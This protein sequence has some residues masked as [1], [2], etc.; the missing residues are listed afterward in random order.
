KKCISALG[1]KVI[2]LEGY[3][4]DDILGTLAKRCEEADA[5]AYLLTGDRD[6]LQLI[7]DHVP[8]LLATN[9]DTVDYTDEVFFE[10]YG[11]HAN[12]YVD[13]KALMGDSSDNIPGIAGIGPKT[14]VNLITEFSTLDG[15]YEGLEASDLKPNMIA[16]LTDGKDSAYLSQTLA[17]INR[18]VPIDTAAEAYKI[19]EIDKE[20]AT[21][22]LSRLGLFKVMAHYS[23]SA[24][25][26]PIAEKTEEKP[27][28]I[29]KKDY[30]LV[31]YPAM[32]EIKSAADG[33]V[34]YIFRDGLIYL[35]AGDKLFVTDDIAGVFSLE[36]EKYTYDCKAQYLYALKNSLP[37]PK[38]SFDLK[39]AAYLLSPTDSDYGFDALTTKFGKAE[40]TLD[41]AA[42]FGDDESAFNDA[43]KLFFLCKT[44]Y[45]ELEKADMLSLLSDI[46]IPL[47][48]T[49]SAMEFEG[50]ELDRE[51]IQAFDRTLSAEIERLRQSIY[52]LAGEEFNVNSPKQLGE[53]LFERLGLPAKKK[54]KTGYSTNA[55]ILERLKERHPIINEILEYRKVSKLKSTYTEGLLLKLGE[56]QRI[57]T[58]FLQTETRTGRLS[59]VEPNLQNIP[60]R[61]EL[62]SRLRE[63]FVAPE[64]RVLVDADYSQIELRVLAHVA[65]DKAMQEAFKS[66]ADIHTATAARVYGLPEMMITP[67]LRRSAKAVNFG[68]VYGIGAYSLSQDIKTSVAE[69]SRLIKS[70]L[71]GFSG[72]ADYMKKTVENGE[73]D[74]FVSTLFNRRRFIPELRN[75]N[76]VVHALGERIAMNTPI[77]G[78]AADIIKIAMNRVYRALKEK[79]PDAKL[80]L[81]VHDEL[82]VECADSDKDK[83]RDILVREMRSAASLK[84]ELETDVHIG[85]TW[86]EAKG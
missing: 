62:G 61:T 56:K 53:I 2:E 73:R 25:D 34:Y 28:E 29:A 22:L 40:Y 51:G 43:C 36:N 1:I 81:Q 9:T 55:E 27:L 5:E 10:K 11:V 80:I 13:V 60:V 65:N 54:T 32:D 50:F 3:E 72:V 82:I 57:H 16:K 58:T 83:V 23:L 69:A 77:Q 33:E 44:L 47:S 19:G 45:S 68:I 66:G 76:K 84:V 38:V 37:L 42:E 63:F 46:E 6:S 24:S 78:T 67:E 52:A 49:L 12:Q 35:T 79:A 14:A 48:E 85:K 71:D 74:G 86:L 39:L 7:S 30:T 8:V 41:F 18:E 70:Y 64:G 15:L 21:A 75:K 26:A 4:A 20:N 59:S 17:T 31:R